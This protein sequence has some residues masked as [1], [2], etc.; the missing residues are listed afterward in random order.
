M[1]SECLENSPF[2]VLEA[3]CSGTPVLGARIGGIPE[4]I[5]EGVTGELFEFRNSFDLESKLV[6]LWNDLERCSRY[7]ANC[8]S[9]EP[10]SPGRYVDA[11]TD[12]YA[13]AMKRNSEEF[14]K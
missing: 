4:L 11:L 6:S 8:A 12:I 2:A 10:M 3:L 13:G 14:S 9:F 7:A 5:D 1:P